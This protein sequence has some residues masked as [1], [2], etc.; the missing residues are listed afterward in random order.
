MS[1][2]AL[3]QLFSPELAA[4]IEGVTPDHSADDPEFLRHD[5][6]LGYLRER[7]AASAPW[8]AL[9]DQPEAFR[10]GAP[11]LRVDPACGFDEAVSQ[12]VC[13]WLAGLAA[14]AVPDDAGDLDFS[15]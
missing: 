11:V 3:H 14:P 13:E 8:L 6:V 5:E 9:D 12:R 2:A 7:N 10:P 1:L 15:R 4:R